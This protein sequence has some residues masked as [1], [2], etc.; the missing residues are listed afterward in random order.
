MVTNFSSSF[1]EVC[2]GLTAFPTLIT[3][4]E[5]KGIQNLNFLDP[6]LM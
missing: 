1:D 2:G 4:F 5:K 3:T 6:D